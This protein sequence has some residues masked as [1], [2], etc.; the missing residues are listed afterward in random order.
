MSSTPLSL[1]SYRT[2]TTT[3]NSATTRIVSKIAYLFKGNI[4]DCSWSDKW[5]MIFNIDKC[6]VMHIVT[7]K[8]ILTTWW[9][10]AKDC[11]GPTTRTWINNHNGFKLWNLVEE[12]YKKNN[13]ALGYVFRSFHFI[14]RNIMLKLHTSPVRPLIESALTKNVSGTDKWDTPPTP[15]RTYADFTWK[16]T[17]LRSTHGNLQIPEGFTLC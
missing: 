6:I 15:W 13:R 9:H 14:F 3:R 4:I 2:L 8:W 16:T 1:A 17:P 12:S 5:Q 11:S 7:R 10:Q